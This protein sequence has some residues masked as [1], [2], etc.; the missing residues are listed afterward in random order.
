MS[1]TITLTAADDHVLTAYRSGGAG[2][3]GGIVIAQEIFGLNRHIRRVCDE[4]A[5]AGFLVVAPAYFDRIA[6]NIEVD[7][8]DIEAARGVVRQL[9]DAQTML[10]TQAAIDAVRGAGKV[11]VI[12]YCWGGF[13]AYLAN[14]R[15]EFDAG[16]SFYGTRILQYLGEAPRAPMLYHWGE[17]DQGLPPQDVARIQAARPE[18]T[19]YVYPGAQHGFNCEDRPANFHAGAATLAY[20]RTLAFL[21]AHLATP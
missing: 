21:A 16:V 6:P 12:G 2:A 11:A 19:H 10:D 14:C 7:Y 20:D 1:E 9:D 4:Y 3:R 17:L 8:G 15:L 5:R 18:G 13:I